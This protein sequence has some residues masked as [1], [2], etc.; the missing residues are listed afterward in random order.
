MDFCCVVVTSSQITAGELLI[1]NISAVLYTQLFSFC[2][3]FHLTRDLICEVKWAAVVQWVDANPD[4]VLLAVG[5]IF[6]LAMAWLASQRL[7]KNA[8]KS[9]SAQCRGLYSF[10]GT[11]KSEFYVRR[12]NGSRLNLDWFGHSKF[13]ESLSCESLRQFLE[14][15]EVSE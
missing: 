7:R 8:Q 4:G 12:D 1:L 9:D 10:V 6:P 14:A 15:A 5:D 13:S 2:L 11:A 3:R